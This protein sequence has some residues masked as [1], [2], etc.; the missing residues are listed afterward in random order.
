MPL[1][2]SGI[3]IFVLVLGGIG[4]ACSHFLPNNVSN[5]DQSTSKQD[6]SQAAETSYSEMDVENKVEDSDVK[7]GAVD[8]AEPISE[9]TSNA[10]IAQEDSAIQIAQRY[11]SNAV[12]Y[13]NHAYVIFDYKDENLDSFDECEEFCERMGGHLAVINSQDENDF[14]Y[15]YVT[16]SGFELAFFGYTDQDTEGQ[17]KWVTD[18]DN[19]YTNWCQVSGR[20]QPNNGSTNPGGKSE[21]YAEFF[22][23]TKDGTWNDAPFGSNT[24][25]FICEWE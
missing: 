7:V 18:S 3:L 11:S 15:N 19:T 21:N 14:L 13:K 1:V 23:N 8:E 5:D 10:D 25:H 9:A 22:K 2:M 24:Y 17:W 6:D 4:L 20:E 12:E 16:D